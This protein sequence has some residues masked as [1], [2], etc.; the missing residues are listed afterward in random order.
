ML[1]HLVKSGS[2]RQVTLLRAGDSEES[3]PLRGQARED[4]AALQGR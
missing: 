2:Q 4:L 3:F 1:S